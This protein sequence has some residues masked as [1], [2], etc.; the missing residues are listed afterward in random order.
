MSDSI[1]ITVP[2][3]PPAECFPNRRNRRG[4]FYPGIEAA[5]TFRMAAKVVAIEHAPSTAISGPVDVALHAAY[6]HKRQLP[7]LDAT[8][9]AAKGCLDGL[10]DGGILVDDRQV[11]RIT[12]SH[13]K[14][15]GKRGE[16]P[17]GCT[18]VTIREIREVAA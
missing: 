10:V 3:E 16:K 12:V 6:G 17:V 2:M 9:S 14:L 13:E 7:D 15:K 5:R 11:S 18:T 8:L 4:G 1:T